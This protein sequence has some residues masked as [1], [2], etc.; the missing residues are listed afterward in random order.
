VKYGRVVFRYTSGQTD[1]HADTLIAILR[2]L[3]GTKLIALW[4]FQ[5]TV[6]TYFCCYVCVRLQVL[7]NVCVCVCVSVTFVVICC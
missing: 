7:V 3:P 5:Q 1:T 2:T 4:M 6:V